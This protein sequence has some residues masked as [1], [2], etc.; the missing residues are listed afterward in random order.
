MPIEI[1][2]DAKPDPKLSAIPKDQANLDVDNPTST[3]VPSNAQKMNASQ[4]T[5][6]DDAASKSTTGELRQNF[7]SISI[8]Q[9]EVLSPVIK[10]EKMS[11]KD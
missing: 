1:T 11:E 3:R 8:V 2:K 5:V 7:R 4:P 9:P 10:E 6:D